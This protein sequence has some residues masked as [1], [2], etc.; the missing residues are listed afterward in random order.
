M[1]RPER[2]IKK[3]HTIGPCWICNGT[4]EVMTD[5]NG[6]T[7][8]ICPMCQPRLMALEEIAQRAGAL[9]TLGAA[10]RLADLSGFAP[11]S[12]LTNRGSYAAA[13]L[14]AVWKVHPDHGGSNGDYQRFNTACELI[15]KHFDD[16][17]L[18]GGTP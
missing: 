9:A 14:R 7:Y 17:T 10:E 11:E 2:F 8:A 16:H 5:G 12:I 1:R 6:A 3:G 13:R 15:E 4:L 18:Q